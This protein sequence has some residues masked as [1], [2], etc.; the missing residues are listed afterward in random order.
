ML[1]YNSGFSS[2]TLVYIS[3][4]SIIRLGQ[5]ACKFSM[6]TSI[7]NEE[8]G[9]IA[10]I[11]PSPTVNV[12]IAKFVGQ[13]FGGFKTTGFCWCLGANFLSL[14]VWRAGATVNCKLH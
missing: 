3:V 9:L 10:S 6:F 2:K 4:F 13:F 5:P 11:P 7:P 1:L 8:A 12:E 14:S